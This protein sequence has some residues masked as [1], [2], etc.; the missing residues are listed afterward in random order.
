MAVLEPLKVTLTDLPGDAPSEVQVPNFPANDKKGC[1]KVSF[2]R[3]I[4]IEQSDFREVNLAFSSHTFQEKC[5]FF[6]LSLQ[7]VI[8]WK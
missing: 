8:Y 6:T 5:F 3:T 7:V 4:Y 2:A 1:H